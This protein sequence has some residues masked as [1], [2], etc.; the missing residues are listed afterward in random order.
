MSKYLV[1][2]ILLG[3]KIVGR[4]FARALQQEFAAS[5]EAARRAGN[6][7]QA[8][9]R[10]VATNIR[11]GITLEEALQILNVQQIDESDVIQRNYKYLIEA[12]DRSKG[13]SFYL[14]SKVVRAKERIDEELKNIK[15]KPPKSSNSR[16]TPNSQL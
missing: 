8:G 5:Q 2:I 10:R 6:N 7:E 12:N 11:T 13:G 1:Q 16:Q 4:A 15:T 9:R 14:Q 3:S